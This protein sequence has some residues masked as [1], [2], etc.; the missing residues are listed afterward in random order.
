M[1]RPCVL[2]ITMLICLSCPATSV[3]AERY[4]ISY[5]QDTHFRAKKIQP[6]VVK[7]LPK[8][9]VL[10]L[11]R[12]KDIEYIVPDHRYKIFAATIDDPKVESFYQLSQTNALL[13]WEMDPLLNRLSPTVAVLDTGINL[14]HQELRG[15]VVGGVNIINPKKSYQ[16]NNGHGTHVA[17]LIGASAN[18]ELGGAG[19]APNANLLSVKVADSKGEGWLS[20]LT[21]GIYWAVDHQAQVINISLGA[22]EV[23]RPLV[24]ALSYARKHNVLV[25]CA[26]GNNSRR[27]LS[28]PANFGACLSVGA[29]DQA[30]ARASFS[31]YGTSLDLVAPG[32]EITSLGFPGNN[33][34]TVY[35]GTSMAAPIV[36]GMAANLIAK[37]YSVEEVE[38]SLKV[39][40]LDLATTGRDDF[41]GSGLPQLDLADKWLSQTAAERSLWGRCAP[42]TQ[43]ITV[44]TLTAVLPISCLDSAGNQTPARIIQPVSRGLQSYDLASQALTW[45]ND[46]P[47]YYSTSNVTAIVA[48]DGIDASPALL[49]IKVEHLKTSITMKLTSLKGKALSCGRTYYQPCVISKSKR[50]KHR[51]IVQGVVNSYGQAM[52][53]KEVYFWFGSSDDIN[54]NEDFYTKISQKNNYQAQVMANKLNLGRYRVELIY[55]GGS[56]LADTKASFFL[57]V[58]K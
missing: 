22:D 26:S 50:Y 24:D 10:R 15:R 2:L 56:I 53:N 3:G 6:I 37:G 12:S 41:T 23:E 54:N 46:Q 43:T 42:V 29:T 51:L 9:K 52:E 49:T 47:D 30:A 44:T 32:V 13:A 38:Q 33:N 34:Y 40:A 27:G 28:S 21:R 5:K 35:S 25:V 7:Y 20:D 14:M 45:T 19:T 39:T 16:D 57:K 31:N 4:I 18:N 55:F 17:G 8:D 36:S 58:E 48:A 11:A 1:L